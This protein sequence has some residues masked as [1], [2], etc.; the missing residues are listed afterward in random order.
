MFGDRLWRVA[1]GPRFEQDCLSPRKVF[2][3]LFSARA[4]Q[5]QCFSLLQS[6]SFNL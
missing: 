2:S 3:C 6:R 1:G 5:I 4:S